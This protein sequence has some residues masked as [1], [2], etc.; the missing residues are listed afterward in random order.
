MSERT[1]AID[2]HAH[3]I[4]P[5][6]V[7]LTRRVGAGDGETAAEARLTY[8]HPLRVRDPMFGGE[9]GSRVE[10]M[11]GAGIATQILSFSSPNVWHRDVA[12]RAA[13]VRTFNEGCLEAC[14]AFPG[15]F[16][17]F[18]NVPMPFVEAALEE[19]SRV[20]DDPDVVGFGICTHAGDLALDDR[21]F[22]PV[23]AEWDRRRAAVLVH[24]DRF[25]TPK[26]LERY[27]MEWGLGAPFDDTIA[28]VRLVRGGV[29]ARYPRITWI[30]PHL[31]G[32]LP[33]LYERLDLLGRRA[34][35]G[36]TPLPPLRDGLAAFLFDT[37]TPSRSGLRLAREVLGADR[38][39]FGSDFPYV[40]RDDL[41]AGLRLLEEAGFGREELAS[42]RGRTML[43]RIPTLAGA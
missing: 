19:T 17:L 40:S 29:A 25:S 8:E 35:P 34:G 5:A 41:G 39:V 43:A 24:P 28:V 37:C 7:E 20:G 11:D 42:A 15:R 30:V 31:G 32:T 10:L 38:L 23:Y 27:G 13:L 21:R 12:M 3:F 14:R 16:K 6:Y 2:V 26:V 9:L 36:G 22:E 33:I 1:G 18:A 4:P